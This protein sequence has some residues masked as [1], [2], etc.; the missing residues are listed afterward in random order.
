MRLHVS[1]I[2]TER[3]SPL[4][5]GV[6]NPKRMTRSILE[7]LTAIIACLAIAHSAQAAELVVMATNA[8]AI[9]GSKVYDIGVRI[10]TADVAAGGNNPTLLVE[11]LTFSGAANGPGQATGSNNKQDLQSVWNTL[12]ALSPGG[13]PSFPTTGGGTIRLYQD[14]WWYSG[15]G[16]TLL[17]VNDSAG[18]T[19]VV[20]TVPAADGSGVYAQG[21][22]AL[23]G[24]TGYLF[25]PIATGI[26]G[27]ATNNSTMSFTGL[28]GPFGADY[29]NP[30]PGAPF[31]DS[32]HILGDLLVQD[33][34]SLTVPLAQ[35]V[36]AGDI[37]IPSPVGPFGTFVSVGQQTYNVDGG[38]QSI[39]Q[40]A[41]LD[42]ATNTIEPTIVIPLTA[43]SDHHGQDYSNYNGS[44]LTLT[45]IDLSQAN[46]SS[47]NFSSA[48]LTSANLNSANLTSTNFSG[49][50]LS[51]ANLQNSNVAQAITAAQLQSAANVT[52]VNLAGNNLSGFDLHGLN[53]S[54]ANLNSAN[55]AS[56]NFSGANLSR[57]FAELE[58]CS[59]HHCRPATVRRQCD[60]REPQQ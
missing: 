42:Y 24:T 40:G 43:F 18:D 4:I 11:N 39:D 54:S 44:G 5:G 8:T 41:F 38:P 46:L 34:G 14:S 59:G 48:N 2:F 37:Q 7:P 3:C 33:G 26:V 36:A 55:L 45:G 23:V 56:A 10:T 51:L 1:I 12:D 49:A 17:G 30:S 28:F 20:T 60:G 32:N 9:A 21:P 53:L 25:Q 35:I 50:N 6:V 13:G 31:S 22:G 19:G 29:L 15:G 16:G 58:R 52:G 57:E 47:A 27:G